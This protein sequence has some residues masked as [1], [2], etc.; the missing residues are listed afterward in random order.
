M[1]ETPIV[2][3]QQNGCR[4]FDANKL[5]Y[6]GDLSSFN[7]H[8]FDSLHKVA[9]FTVESDLYSLLSKD[10]IGILARCLAQLEACELALVGF[11]LCANLVEALG[12]KPVF[13]PLGEVKGFERVQVLIAKLQ[14][15]NKIVELSVAPLV[16]L[17]VNFESLAESFPAHQ[18]DELFNQAATLTVS[19]AVN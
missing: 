17:E 5:G 15:T 1:T 12:L 14:S 6:V 16:S 19:N 7:I 4:D 10:L 11:I 13:A 18:E 3:V 9:V 2:I 8:L